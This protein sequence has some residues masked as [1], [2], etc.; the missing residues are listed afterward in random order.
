MPGFLALDDN[1]VPIWSL[2]PPAKEDYNG[3]K[4]KIDFTG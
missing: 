4:R 2:L 3:N 1:I